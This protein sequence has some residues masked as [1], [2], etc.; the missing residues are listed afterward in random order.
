[1]CQPYLDDFGMDKKYKSDVLSKKWEEVDTSITQGWYKIPVTFYDCIPLH[2]LL[3]RI[4]R[5]LLHERGVR[6]ERQNRGGFNNSLFIIRLI[7]KYVFSYSIYNATSENL[8]IRLGVRVGK[9][10]EIFYRWEKT[11]EWGGT[12]T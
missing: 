11:I 12:R 2:I 6:K 10:I 8:L 7:V 4:P 3:T 9:V 1:M 5:T